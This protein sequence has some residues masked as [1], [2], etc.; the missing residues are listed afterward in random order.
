MAPLN[1]HVRSVRDWRT[2]RITLDYD[3]ER[4]LKGFDYR[5]P[6]AA[7]RACYNLR[8]CG[9]LESFRIDPTKKGYHVVCWLTAELTYRESLALREMLGD[10]ALRTGLDYFRPPWAGGVL[11]SRKQGR[12]VVKGPVRRVCE[13]DLSC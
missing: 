9:L 1:D 10:D 11:W 3:R 4:R 2:R 6:L 12:P 8:A 7:L 13:I 5:P